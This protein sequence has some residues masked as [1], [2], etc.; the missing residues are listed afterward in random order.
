MEP[1]D[2]TT[3][4]QY[5]DQVYAARRKD[6]ERESAILRTVI[7]EHAR[8]PSRTL[9][10]VGCGTGNHLQYLAREFACTGV[11][12]NPHMIAIAKRKV[13][14]AHFA[15]ADMV[16]FQLTD[17]FDV[18]T[19]LFSSIGYVQTRASLVKTLAGFHRHLHDRGLV[20][21]EPWVFKTDYRKGTIS[22]TTF[23]DEDLKL[24]R[25]ATSQHPS[26]PRLR[27]LHKRL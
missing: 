19:C 8:R 18:V 22:L 2:F 16:H 6:Y 1:R 25:M 27:R 14:R 20:I 11:D 26:P 4:A 21:V 7:H 10:D 3:F 23:E 5:Y 12:I 17:R 9:L 24:A 13:P 15:V